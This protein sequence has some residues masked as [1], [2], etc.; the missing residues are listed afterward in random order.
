M[1]VVQGKQRHSLIS[2]PTKKSTV[3]SAETSV[4]G[5]STRCDRRV[6]RETDTRESL[7]VG[8]QSR[9]NVQRHTE[10]ALSRDNLPVLHGLQAG[11]RV[12]RHDHRSVL[13]PFEQITPCGYGDTQRQSQTETHGPRVNNEAM[14]HSKPSSCCK[15]QLWR[16]PHCR[17]MP[18]S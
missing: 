6:H 4:G 7:C 2:D 11:R 3:P 8:A 18:M 9:V 10:K 14:Q 16:R 13:S 1:V 12:V 17:T 15:Q 5:G